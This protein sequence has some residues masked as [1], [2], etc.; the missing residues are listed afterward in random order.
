MRFD[1]VS[2][3]LR[4]DP[5]VC[6]RALACARAARQDRFD[7]GIR[8]LNSLSCTRGAVYS[9][10]LPVWRLVNAP[11]ATWPKE[12]RQ[13]QA[14]EIAQLA[15]DKIHSR[16]SLDTLVVTYVAHRKYLLAQD[17]MDTVA[18]NSAHPR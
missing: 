7:Q 11:S 8:A 13:S 4:G 15:Y 16:V 1:E 6:R 10:V 18:G 17:L 5:S 9:N 14:R 12:R 3:A 2:S